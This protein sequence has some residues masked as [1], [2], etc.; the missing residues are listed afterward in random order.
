MLGPIAQAWFDHKLKKVQ[1]LFEDTITGTTIN[2][3]R[4]SIEWATAEM[5]ALQT[6]MDVFEQELG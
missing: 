6:Y 2:K 4:E 3:V 5:A 1:E